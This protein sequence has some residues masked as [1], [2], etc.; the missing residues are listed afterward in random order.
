MEDEVFG[1]INE[2]INKLCFRIVILLDT[3][4]YNIF[5]EKIIYI[6]R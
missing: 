6:L 3:K 4:N 1:G 5:R 2:F